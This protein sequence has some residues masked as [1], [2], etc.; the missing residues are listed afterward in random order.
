MP[1]EK[2]REWR[3]GR[4]LS[5]SGAAAALGLS[6]RMVAYYDQG[7][8]PIPKYVWLA[9]RGYDAEPE[10][11]SRTSGKGHPLRHRG[12]QIGRES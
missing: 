11:Q 3:A 1:T 4:R 6:R 9:T 5:L 8:K 7:A 12:R 2:F 10:P